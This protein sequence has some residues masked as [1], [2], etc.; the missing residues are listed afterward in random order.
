MRRWHSACSAAFRGGVGKHCG[1]QQL[2]L[3]WRR[4]G[5]GRSGNSSFCRILPRRRRL[6]KGSKKKQAVRAGE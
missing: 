5:D 4:K 3:R 1:Q 2:R 6:Q